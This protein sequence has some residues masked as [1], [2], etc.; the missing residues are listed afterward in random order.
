MKGH[1]NYGLSSSEDY[2]HLPNV[3]LHDH[4]MSLDFNLLL[5]GAG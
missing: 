2:K 4:L 5:D 1:G 3:H